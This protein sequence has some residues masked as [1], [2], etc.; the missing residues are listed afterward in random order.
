MPEN[1]TD[2]WKFEHFPTD[3]T[4]EKLKPFSDIISIWQSKHHKNQLPKW[5]DFDLPDFKGWH[6]NLCLCDVME[7]KEDSRFR[8]WGSALSEVFNQNAT[9]ML[10]SEANVNYTTYDRQ[11]YREFVEEKTIMRCDGTLDWLGKSYKHAT[12]LHLPLSENG[13]DVDR[14]L[15]LFYEQNILTD[16]TL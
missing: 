2:E 3:I 5:A 10:L 16:D 9:G 1:T 6:Q 11:Q 14:Y 13:R 7:N 15:V 4:P 12:L 8:I